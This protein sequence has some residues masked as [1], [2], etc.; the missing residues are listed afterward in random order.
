VL[1]LR[2]GGEQGKEGDLQ[3]RNTMDMKRR[4]SPLHMF[5]RN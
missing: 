1:P 2:E 5:D 3:I 4:Q